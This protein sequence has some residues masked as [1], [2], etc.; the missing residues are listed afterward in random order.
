FQDWLEAYQKNKGKLLSGLD[1]DMNQKVDLCACLKH[2][3]KKG[4]LSKEQSDALKRY[5]DELVKEGNL[6]ALETK[7]ELES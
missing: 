5:L 7:E 2:R 6:W 1:L 4:H 3:L